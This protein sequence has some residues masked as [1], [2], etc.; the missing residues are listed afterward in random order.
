MLFNAIRPFSSPYNRNF[1]LW[2][3]FPYPH[4]LFSSL[5]NIVPMSFC[6]SCL[7]RLAGASS[8]G[9]PGGAAYAGGSAYPGAYPGQQ[10][11][12]VPS[13]GGHTGGGRGGGL[14]GSLGGLGGVLG[15]ATMGAAI[16]NPVSNIWLILSMPKIAIP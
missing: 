15:A 8:S 11:M 4:V 6:F 10:Q 2:I 13:M 14:L 16:L 7:Q 12:G 9:Y 3:A 1:N 5:Q